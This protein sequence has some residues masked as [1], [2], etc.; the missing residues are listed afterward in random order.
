MIYVLDACAM[1]AL[2][3]GEPGEEVVWVHL[4]EKDA[5]CVAH[6]VNLC[7]VFYDFYR[8]LGEGLLP[9]KRLKTLGGSG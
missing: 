8:D 2:P 5:S 9:V 6:S 1:I 4:L 7:E 3:L